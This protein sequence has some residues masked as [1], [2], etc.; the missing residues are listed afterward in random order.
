MP[1]F[2]PTDLPS[3]SLDDGVFL[4]ICF[5]PFWSA[6]SG[7]F[8]CVACFG[9]VRSDLVRPSEVQSGPDVLEGGLPSPSHRSASA[10]GPPVVG[11]PGC[12]Q[13]LPPHC[14]GPSNLCPVVRAREMCGTSVCGASAFFS[15][16]HS[17]STRVRLKLDISEKNVLKKASEKKLQNL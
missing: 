12:N 4:F 14:R 2:P 11:G 13:G 17:S 16:L 9:P 1:T 15:P 7:S 8:A 10:T 6:Q 3:H 5:G